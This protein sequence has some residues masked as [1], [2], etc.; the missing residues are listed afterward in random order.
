MYGEK[1]NLRVK[2][3]LFKLFFTDLMFCHFLAAWLSCRKVEMV[4]L[5][6]TELRQKNAVM[7]S[8]QGDLLY[9]LLAAPK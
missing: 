8:E 2:H 7:Y 9:S 5:Q 6:K 1:Y 4:G 3:C